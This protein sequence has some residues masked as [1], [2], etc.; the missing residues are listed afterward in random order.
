MSC[1]YCIS[2]LFPL[3]LYEYYYRLRGVI[4]NK[5]KPHKMFNGQRLVCGMGDIFFVV[6][7]QFSSSQ[8]M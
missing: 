3:L 4:S 5:L 7:G 2:L 6:D 8:G 1:V